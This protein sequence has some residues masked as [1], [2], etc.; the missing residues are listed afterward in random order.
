MHQIAKAKVLATQAPDLLMIEHEVRRL[1]AK[2]TDEAMK[3][4]LAEIAAHISRLRLE[5]DLPKPGDVRSD[6]RSPSMAVTHLYA[7]DDRLECALSDLS[8]GGALVLCD[9]VI[10]DEALIHLAV[11]GVGDLAGIVVATTEH[12][13]HIR[14]LPLSPEAESALIQA[15]ARHYDA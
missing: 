7:G 1:C 5:S 12:G 15:L 2:A 8:I 9:V 13:S 3:E 14:F 11:P 6:L 10:K 4:S